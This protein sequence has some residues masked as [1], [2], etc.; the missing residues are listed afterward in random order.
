MNLKSNSRIFLIALI[1][2]SLSLACTANDIGGNNGS[3]SPPVQ[4]TPTNTSPPPNDPGQSGQPAAATD[5]SPPP[6]LPPSPRC[7]PQTP[8]A[9]LILSSWRIL[10]SPMAL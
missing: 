4:P 5:T 9:H 8:P 6:P 10:A 3:D 2:F 7:R 1:L